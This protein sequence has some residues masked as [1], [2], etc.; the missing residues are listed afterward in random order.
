MRLLI[1]I[2]P[3]RMPLMDVEYAHG[4]IALY[5]R[6]PRPN[7]HVRP[8]SFRRAFFGLSALTVIGSVLAVLVMSW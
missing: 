4:L 8:E 1:H 3:P 5:G 2:D 7:R 6:T